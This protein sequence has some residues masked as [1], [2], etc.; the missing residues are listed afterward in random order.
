QGAGFDNFLGTVTV[1]DCTIAHNSAGTNGGGFFNFGN[2]T[3]I[4]STISD[5]SAGTGGGLEVDAGT[6]TITNCTIA[7]NSAGGNG[8]GLFV[9]TNPS[10]TI[11]NST[12]AN[13]S[14]TNGA[15]GVVNAGNVTLSSTIVAGN[16][17]G[18]WE[19]FHAMSSS[20]NN[21]IG[22]GGDSGLGNGINGNI[23]GTSQNPIDPLLGPLANNGG[24]TQTMALLPGSPAI[25]A[26]G[27][28]L[29]INP[30]TQLQL[31]TDQ[32]GAGFSRFV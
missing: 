4:N 32:R 28:T 5:N 15:G 1:T 21:L 6:V 14:A 22:N 27:T 30:L 16:T 31:T 29:P 26:A 12:I 20:S 3:I 2:L 25:D 11:K 9:S 23:V 7:D 24:P 17:G 18:D 19:G 8:G 13:N 10:V